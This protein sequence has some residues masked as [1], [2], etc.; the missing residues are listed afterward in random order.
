M[1][2]VR[3]CV[4]LFPSDPLRLQNT[5]G[6]NRARENCGWS[7][8]L[9]EDDANETCTARKHLNP[10]HDFVDGAQRLVI[11]ESSYGVDVAGEIPDTGLIRPIFLDMHVGIFEQLLAALRFLDNDVNRPV[12]SLLSLRTDHLQRLQNFLGRSF[13][14][15]RL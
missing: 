8:E 13:M 15:K 6:K 14:H 4:P 10:R 12:L 11:R 7:H 1:P 5:P 9:N 2:V 3:T